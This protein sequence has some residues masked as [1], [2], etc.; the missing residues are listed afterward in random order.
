LKK[1]LVS[2]LLLTTIL[3]SLIYPL[4]ILLGS[5]KI[6][7]AAAQKTIKG[8]MVIPANN[9]TVLE[10]YD[11]TIEGN[12]KVE[13]GGL[14]ILKN[15]TI[16]ISQSKEYQ[17]GVIIRGRLE[18]SFSSI[19]PNPRRPLSYNITVLGNGFVWL[20]NFD[21]SRS[22]TTCQLILGDSATLVGDKVNLL[23]GFI[24]AKKHSSLRLTNSKIKP[25]SSKTPLTLYDFS[26]VVLTKTSVTVSATKPLFKVYNFSRLYFSDVDSANG[27]IHAYDYSKLSIMNCK[28]DLSI[29]LYHSSSVIINSGRFKSLKAYNSSMASIIKTISVKE[30][31]ISAYD[32]STVLLHSGRVTSAF[33]YNNSR[34]T[35]INSA[36]EYGFTMS[37]G[38]VGAYDSADVMLTGSTVRILNAYKSSVVSLSN[39]T[40]TWMARASSFSSL[41]FD[42]CQIG[43]FAVAEASS[44]NVS[45]SHIA[46]LDITNSPKVYI[47]NSVIDEATFNFKSVNISIAGLGPF[48][49]NH[50]SSTGN[51]TL[52]T[53][54]GYGADITLSRTKIQYGLNLNLFGSSNVSIFD[55]R[56]KHLGAYDSTTI[57]LFNSTATSHYIGNE[58]RMLTYW[59][60]TVYALNGTNIK[61]FYQNGTA[62]I[63]TLTVV[64]VVKFPLLEKVVCGSSVYTEGNYKFNAEWNGNSI[65]RE[66]KMGD[67]VVIDLTP[68]K[69]WQPDLNTIVAALIVICAVLGTSLFYLKRRKRPSKTA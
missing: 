32:V 30:V 12:I 63:P 5:V 64:D 25:T 65:Q 53:H 15:T 7:L 19:I 22:G 69:S 57:C 39:T 60:L 27:I 45:N 50:W 66:I 29:E 13:E 58:T 9:I 26:D 24:I 37:G 11:I 36:V 23:E 56:L 34:L 4:P 43:T 41:S 51:G 47:V 31:E 61:V 35:I 59:Y 28:G 3:L 48:Y 10:N 20:S 44:V 68:P 49:C 52:A 1:P 33:A 16:K 6:A 62:A 67:N 38:V 14:L 21:I 2:A 18:A 55:S 54:G 40:I 17:Y 8:D 46:S 42:K